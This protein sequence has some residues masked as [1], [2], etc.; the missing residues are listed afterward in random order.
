MKIPDGLKSDVAAPLLCAGITVYSPMMRHGLG[1][2]PGKKV[3]VIALGGV[4][5]MA[6][7]IAKAL[8]HHVTVFS[9]STSKK[10]EAM[11]VLGADDFLVTTDEAAMK[12]IS[13]CF[14][15]SIEFGSL[16]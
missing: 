8:G 7:K 11:G 16:F 13:I 2:Q 15:C 4:G 3:G 10:E 6:V 12:V 1:D 14:N 9:T 5:H